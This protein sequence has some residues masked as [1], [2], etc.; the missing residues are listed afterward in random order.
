MPPAL[1]IPDA[2]STSISLRRAA[3]AV[4]AP[5]AA[6]ASATP[7]PI[8]LLAPVT[9]ATRSNSC[10]VIVPSMLF[11]NQCGQ[12]NSFH[13]S[14][15]WRRKAARAPAPSANGAA[16]VLLIKSRGGLHA[17]YLSK[18]CFKARDDGRRRFCWQEDS[19]DY[20]QMSRFAPPALGERGHSCLARRRIALL[21]LALHRRCRQVLHLEPIRRAAGAI[22]RVL[23]LR[24]DAF[25]SHL[26]G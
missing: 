17:H 1:R 10:L 18:P 8:P 15:D 6:N 24:H 2:T 5:A 4:F 23:P 13:F 7:R 26:A 12:S 11:Q 22:H 16:C 19:S 9:M 21:R 3:N 20:R 25:E 14:I